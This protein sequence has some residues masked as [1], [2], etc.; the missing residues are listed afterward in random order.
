M[1]RA[2]K[3]V[4]Q[5]QVSKVL[6]VGGS[7]KDI[8][9]P[10]IY[11]GWDHVLLDIDPKGKPDLVC[12][13]RNLVTLP[14][15]EYDAIYCSHNLEHYYHHDV[16]KVLKGFLHLLK[17]DGFVYILVPDIKDLMEVVVAKNL[18]IDDVIYTSPSGPMM[19]RDVMYGWGV[20]IEQ[21]GQDYYAHKTGFT[22]LS[23]RKT[24]HDIGFSHVYVGNADLEIKAIAFKQA[25]SEDIKKTL[26]L[27]EIS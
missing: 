27:P 9:L 22:P 3:E 10:D 23:L 8:Q 6:N 15:G 26:N 19:V 4:K 1:S 24:L 20:E 17:Q 7:S 21:S 16:E 2:K 11:S 14:A 25:P 13:A 12:D 5:S 18:D